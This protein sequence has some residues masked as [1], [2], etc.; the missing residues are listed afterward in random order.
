[1]ALATHF[2]NIDFYHRYTNHCNYQWFVSRSFWRRLKLFSHVKVSWSNSY[3]EESMESDGPSIWLIRSS[4][5][6][7]GCLSVFRL[8]TARPFNGF[9]LDSCNLCSQNNTTRIPFTNVGNFNCHKYR[10]PQCQ[11]LVA[12]DSQIQRL[13][14]NHNRLLQTQ[15]YW[16]CRLKASW[17][18]VP[19][20]FSRILW[21]FWWWVSHWLL[22]NDHKEHLE[23]GWT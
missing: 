13:P 14:F 12:P 19:L 6:T 2:F 18:P 11:Y 9:D 5:S 22:F 1:M 17:S 4:A 10:R 15:S 20:I 23:W 8:W 3:N 16:K 7:E 21:R